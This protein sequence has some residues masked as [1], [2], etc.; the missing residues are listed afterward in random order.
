[1]I[2]PTF[3]VPDF[4]SKVTT[5]PLPRSTLD[6]ITTPLALIVGGT[7]SGKVRALLDDE[8]KRVNK[9][10]PSTPVEVLGLSGTPNAGDLAHVV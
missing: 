9:A 2:C 3:S 6:S 8:G 1:M 7:E 5:E 4:T 10:G